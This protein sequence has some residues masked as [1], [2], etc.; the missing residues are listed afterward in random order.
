MFRG[1]GA[2]NNTR[3][4]IVQI[5]LSKLGKI[6]I[7]RVVINS[8]KVL[9]FDDLE[10]KEIVRSQ[11][12]TEII[13]VKDDMYTL[14]YSRKMKANNEIYSYSTLEFNPCKI[15][16]GHNIYNANSNELKNTIIGII[17]NLKTR[18][19]DIDISEAKIKEIEINITLPLSFDQLQEIILLIGRA[20]YKKALGM[21]SF[22]NEDIPGMIKKDRS[23]YLNSGKENTGKVIKIYDKT[24]EIYSK[25]G[26]MLDENLT[27]LEVLFGQDYYRSTLERIGLDNDLKTFI[28]NNI[29]SGIFRQAIETEIVLRPQKYISVIKKRLLDEFLNF[30]RNEK[31]KREYREK[32]K[33]QGKEIPE[34]Y[35]EERGVFEYLKKEAWIFDCDFLIEIVN[36]NI[37]SKR[38][39]D[40]IKQIE[41]KYKNIK[42]MALLK[43]F[44]KKILGDFFYPTNPK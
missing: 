37:P 28:A 25:Q 3:G 31:V 20:N 5:V 18:G 42:N 6:G 21:Y 9:N 2:G 44:Y 22:N 32:L 16:D 14:I 4:C 11:D 1:S 35:K 15:A 36:R 27:R 39:Y 34:E 10:K 23:L 13:E 43:D 7:D 40:Y 41:K 19:I 26:I 33:I 30:R 38:R 17:N 12:I 8:F 24:F 29:T